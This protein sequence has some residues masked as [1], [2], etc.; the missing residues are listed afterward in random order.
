MAMRLSIFKPDAAVLERCKAFQG[1]Q[2]RLFALYA[3]ERYQEALVLSEEAAQR[4]PEYANRLFFWIVCLQSR[5]GRVDQAIQTLRKALQ[6][7][8]WWSTR[9]LLGDPDLKPLRERPEF[10]DILVACQHRYEE[11][12]RSAEPA[13]IIV[14]PKTSRKPPPLLLALHGAG[15]MIME[16]AVYWL[17]AVEAGWLLALPQSSQVFDAGTFAWKDSEKAE[18]EV[19][20]AYEHICDTLVFDTNR[21]ILAG[22]SQGGALAISLALKGKIPTV[23][24]LAVAPA[25]RE[26]EVARLPMRSAGKRGIRGY[27]LTGEK[28][29]GL[30][31]IKEFNRKARAEGLEC[32]LSVEPG[33]GHGFP[34][35]FAEK[36]MEGLAFLAPQAPESTAR[37]HDEIMEP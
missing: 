7:G 25:F 30:P 8:H 21:V 17:S 24:F 26:K 1:F 22:F 35:E 19:Q 32:K 5:L 14:E 29:F 4:F 12:Q 31:R 16:E 23:G 20:A 28:D 3:Q 13:L 11:A 27:V 36:L 9:R 10:Q 33:L 18:R 6:Q 34:E 37:S 15:S 2:K